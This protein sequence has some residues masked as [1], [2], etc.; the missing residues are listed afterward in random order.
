[1]E[2]L[3]EIIKE[4]R[5]QK[6]MT[7]KQLAH[8]TTL[9][10]AY[11]S[12]IERNKRKPSKKVLLKLSKI[13]DI[14]IAKLIA[15]SMKLEEQNKQDKVKKDLDEFYELNE[16]VELYQELAKTHLKLEHFLK[17]N[18]YVYYKDIRLSEKNKDKILNML[19]ILFE[20]FEDMESN[21]PTIEEFKVILQKQKEKEL[22]AKKEEYLLEL[23]EQNE[24][25][26]EE[27]ENFDLDDIEFL[28]E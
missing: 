17:R 16:E 13:L 12:L 6:G 14:D 7:L 26:Q 22:E 5:K 2:N 9:T 28:D 18:K 19:D 24:I 27:Y 3:G 4:A 1:M 23:L 8:E 25:T 10:D 15:A 11:L 21:Y 20:E